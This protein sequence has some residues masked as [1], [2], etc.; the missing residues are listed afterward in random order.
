MEDALEATALDPPASL[1]PERIE[2]LLSDAEAARTRIREAA[3]Q[4][5]HRERYRAEMAEG[6][7][8]RV[9]ADLDPLNE[10][11]VTTACAR[12]GFGVERQRGR[13]RFSIDF[14]NEALV[15]TLPGVPGGAS[16]LGTFD[17]EEAVEDETLDF[18]AAGHPLVEGILA[19]L[20]ESPRGRVAVLALPGARADEASPRSTR[21]DRPS[22]WWRSTTKATLVRTGPP[23]CAAARS[24]RAGRRE[25]WP[26]IRTG[27]TGWSG[28]AE[29]LRLGSPARGPGRDRSAMALGAVR[30]RWVAR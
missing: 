29:S 8:A 2:T 30:R 6:I 9:P 20:E 15:D 17:R 27:P 18:F 12:L 24:H 7:L 21:T 3:Y 11:V 22:R 4:E 23:S 19:H 13:R 16:F 26:T 1:S 10:D 28:V 5:L 25:T 14:G